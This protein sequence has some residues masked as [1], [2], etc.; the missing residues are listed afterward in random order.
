[1]IGNQAT[2]FS[3]SNTSAKCRVCARLRQNR[4]HRMT[5][6]IAINAACVLMSDTY[7]LEE[8]LPIRINST[9]D[10]TSQQTQNSSQHNSQWNQQGKCLPTHWNNLAGNN[11]TKTLHQ[12]DQIYKCYS[13]IFTKRSVP[14]YYGLAHLDCTSLRKAYV[15]IHLLLLLFT[16]CLRMLMQVLE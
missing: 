16:F 5:E 4:L 15:L 10:I 7:L 14:N 6:S 12:N 3:Q 11:L 9:T 2:Y 13:C 1:M 8:M